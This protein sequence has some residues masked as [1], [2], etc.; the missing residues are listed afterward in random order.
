MPC[1]GPD[2]HEEIRRR[3]AALGPGDE[4]TVVVLREGRRQP[5]T[6]RIEP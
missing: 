4:V 2:S 5:L 1:T 6:T 3:V